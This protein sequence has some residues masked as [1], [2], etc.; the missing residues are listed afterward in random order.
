MPTRRQFNQQL[1]AL[2]TGLGLIGC[3]NV[4]KHVKRTPKKGTK[5]TIY[6]SVSGSP[7]ENVAKTL[8][9]MGGVEH[10]FGRDDVIAI[11]PNCQQWNQGS[12]NLAAV[13]AF[14]DAIMNRTGGFSGDIV[15]VENNHRG[16]KP[17]E[18]AGWKK[19]FERNSDIDG[20]YNY[21]ELSNSLK[22]RYGD[23][24]AVV[25]WI[26]VDGGSKKVT[27]PEDGPGYVMC[28]G[29][30]GVPLLKMGNNREGEL[31]REVI[32]SYPVFKTGRGAIVDYK[33]GV[34]E[35]GKFS[36]R[37]FKYI[38]CAALN[39]HSEYCGPTSAVKNYFGVVD[40]SGG[41]DPHNGGIMTDN[42]YNF[43]SFPFDKWA[44][45]PTPG[46]MGREVG[47]FLRTIRNPFLNFVTAEYIGVVDR[48]D[49]PVARTKCVLMSPDP[50]AMDYHTAKYILY[51]NSGIKKHNP[52]F[53]SGPFYADLK[54]CADESGMT[55][56]EAFVDI[57]SYD[58]KARKLQNDDELVVRG[59]IDWSFT[60]KTF[61]KYLLF[62]SGLA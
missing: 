42:Y 8:E 51:P 50:V 25:H 60:K 39:H 10:L 18:Y 24:F 16:S 5:S 11:K 3:S 54:G 37:E 52:D 4:N 15:F 34:W 22:K 46:M 21:T 13:E 55:L 41:P 1:A 44:K 59:E 27:K 62:R 38:N 20:V 47:M 61:V 2:A 53:K 48:I 57:K 14:V 28:D 9:L 45:G 49:P 26:D 7:Q 12:P 30:N 35:N 29:K 6:R 33:H 32:M 19:G 43:H 40:L 31:F 17:W 58:H 36:E 23:Q 56:D